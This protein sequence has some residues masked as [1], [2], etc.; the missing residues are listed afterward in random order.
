MQR[1]W[2]DRSVMRLP[3]AAVASVPGGCRHVWEEKTWSGC[4]AWGVL[5]LWFARS[6]PT[7]MGDTYLLGTLNGRTCMDMAGGLAG[8]EH[9]WGAFATRTWRTSFDILGELPFL[10]LLDTYSRYI[11]TI[12]ANDHPVLVAVAAMHRNR[13]E[14]FT[15]ST[16][17]IFIWPQ[18]GSG[19]PWH[20]AGL[21]GLRHWWTSTLGRPSRAGLGRNESCVE[22][23]S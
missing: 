19:I 8:Y 16:P 23:E 17:C 18:N 5:I 13:S 14:T 22:V 2:Q 1:R 20:H 7:G 15:E 3:L 9:V 21:W 6:S 10:A 4:A 12:I 11:R